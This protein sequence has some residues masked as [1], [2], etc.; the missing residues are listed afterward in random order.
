MYK[1]DGGGIFRAC[2]LNLSR[3]QTQLVGQK[4]NFKKMGNKSVLIF[5]TFADSGEFGGWSSGGGEGWRD[6]SRVGSE[7]TGTLCVIRVLLGRPP[8]EK[9]EEVK[10]ADLEVAEE[11]GARTEDTSDSLVHVVESLGENSSYKKIKKQRK[12]KNTRMQE[13]RRA[14]RLIDKMPTTTV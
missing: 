6:A 5:L 9:E 2:K 8:E 12:Q 10:E 14:C 4:S 11:D 3:V 13:K 1:A 7:Q